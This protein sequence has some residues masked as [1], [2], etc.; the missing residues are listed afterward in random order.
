MKD[1]QMP[2]L[3]LTAERVRRIIV[4]CYYYANK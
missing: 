2:Q 4:Y 1:P 3:D